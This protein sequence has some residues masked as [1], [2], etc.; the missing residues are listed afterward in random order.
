MFRAA[1]LSLRAYEVLSVSRF[2]VSQKRNQG[3]ALWAGLR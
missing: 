2:D 3:V 1:E